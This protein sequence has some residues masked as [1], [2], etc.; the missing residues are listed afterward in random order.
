MKPSTWRCRA[1]GRSS[2]YAIVDADGRGASCPRCW[3][4]YNSA[5]TTP[6][7]SDLLRPAAR[8]GAQIG[9]A[10]RGP[11]GGA[12]GGATGAILGALADRVLTRPEIQPAAR[13]ARTLFGVFSD[14]REHVF[15]GN[16][17]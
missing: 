1:C 9:A 11:R 4:S 17:G 6:V 7:T 3:R 14:I 12:L 13:L 8:V 5:P 2:S 16:R 15:K 10:A